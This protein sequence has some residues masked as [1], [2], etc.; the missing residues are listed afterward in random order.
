MNSWKQVINNMKLST[1]AIYV[2]A[3]PWHWPKDETVG[4]PLQ[5]PN[6]SGSIHSLSWNTGLQIASQVSRQRTGESNELPDDQSV[7]TYFLCM[8]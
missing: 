6:S 4:I 2:E 1:F 7:T 5:T 3:W 8:L